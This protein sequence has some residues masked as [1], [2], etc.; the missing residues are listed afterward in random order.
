MF[1]SLFNFISNL[2]Y[3][4]G[5]GALFVAWTMG[6]AK[7]DFKYSGYKDRRAARDFA[8]NAWFHVFIAFV[9]A[10]ALDPHIDFS[11]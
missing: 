9:L 4:Y 1:S 5:L 11:D 7:N 3:L 10:V 6:K 8:T 2:L